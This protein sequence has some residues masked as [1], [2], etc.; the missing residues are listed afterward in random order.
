MSSP[1]V[2]V[3]MIFLNEERFITEALHSVRSQTY[4]DWELLLIDD[5]STDTS[6]AIARDEAA[7]YP[8]TVRYFDHPG[9]ANRGMSAS[10]SRVNSEALRLTTPSCLPLAK[11]RW[12]KSLH[13]CD[14]HASISNRFQQ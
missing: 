7:R 2:S 13:F 14:E 10:R 8:G 12:K 11:N 9:H 4:T 5:G 1:R 6:T 3:V